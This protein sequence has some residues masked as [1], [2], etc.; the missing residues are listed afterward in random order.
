MQRLVEIIRQHEVVSVVM[1]LP[2][3]MDG[4]EGEMAKSV[5]ELI[6]QL[7]NRVSVPIVAWDERLS[8]VQAERAL[9]DMGIP[10]RARKRGD[11]DR[12]AA[13]F[14]LQSYLDSLKRS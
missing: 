1:G 14:I 3:H 5:R 12:L 11:V 7:A 13:M 10:A 2:R 8:S 6:T 4:N 9:R